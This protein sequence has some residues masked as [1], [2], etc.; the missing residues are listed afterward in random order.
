[1]I[2][3]KALADYFK[4][5]C[6][7]NKVLNHREGN[8]SFFR[9]NSRDV[10]TKLSK[11]ASVIFVLES[12]DHRFSDNTGDSIMKNKTGA[13]SIAKL[14]EKQDDFIAQDDAVDFCEELTE[15]ILSAMRKDNRNFNAQLFG[16][17]DFNTVGGF[18][19]GPIYGGYWGIRTE[20]TFGDSVSLKYNPS[21]WN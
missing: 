15:E 3:H 12:P 6:Q 9:M 14:V 11:A 21:K 13:F 1:M 10:T 8:P 19:V 7:K 20:F 2:S 5:L 18:K 4:T 17:L 16:H